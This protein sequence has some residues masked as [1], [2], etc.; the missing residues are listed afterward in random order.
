M[1][2]AH[3]QVHISVYQRK[4]VS[5]KASMLCAWNIGKCQATSSRQHR[6][7]PTASVVAF[8]HHSVDVV[9]GH[10]ESAMGYAHHLAIIEIDLPAFPFCKQQQADVECK[11]CAPEVDYILLSPR[12]LWTTQIDLGLYISHNHHHVWTAHI[13]LGLQLWS[14]NITHCLPPSVLP[15]KSVRRRRSWHYHIVIDLKQNDSQ[16]WTWACCIFFGL[17]TLISRISRG[18]FISISTVNLCFPL[19][20]LTCT[21][22]KAIIKHGLLAS[23]VAYTLL[24]QYQ[25]CTSR[26]GCSLSTSLVSVRFGVPASPFSWKWLL[27]DIKCFLPS[28]CPTQRSHD[29]SYFMP[30]HLLLA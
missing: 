27:K 14:R 5:A 21:Q 18:L 12:R 11:M 7:C 2:C 24:N 28:L 25:S 16:D 10:I 1:A 8:V 22:Q 4:G 15:Y 19:Y 26:M 13:A 17:H 6:L 23:V 3:R 9:C 20:P 30:H 29:V